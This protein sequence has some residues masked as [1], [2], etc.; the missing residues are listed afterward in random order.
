M[1]FFHYHV[2]FVCLLSVT[3]DGLLG[4][5]INPNPHLSGEDRL[6][7]LP[8]PLLCGHRGG[9]EGDLH[10][11]PHVETLRELPGWH[12]QS[13]EHQAAL[14]TFSLHFES[15]DCSDT[16]SIVLFLWL[17]VCNNTSDRKHADTVLERYVT[18]T[19]MSIV[20]TFFSSPFSDQSTSLQVCKH[21]HLHLKHLQ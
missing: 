19:V 12:L 13:K 18:E 7:Q 5:Y 11:Q 15:E 10:L 6:Y 21:L 3:Y 17:Q 1:I 20:T 14:W 4:F 8:E 16:G 9:N 2:I